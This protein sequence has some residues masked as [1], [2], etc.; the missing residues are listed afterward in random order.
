M[1]AAVT[2]IPPETTIWITK[3]LTEWCPKSLEGKHQ[4]LVT[5]YVDLDIEKVEQ[6]YVFF[7]SVSD[8]F[9]KLFCF[10]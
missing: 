3:R 2:A 6:I 7:H 10:L 5:L 1:L 9:E 4:I 8:T